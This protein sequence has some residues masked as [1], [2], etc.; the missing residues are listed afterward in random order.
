MTSV[1]E[2]GS[3]FVLYLPEKTETAGAAA[4]P[5]EPGKGEE[6]KEDTARPPVQIPE[7]IPEEVSDDRKTIQP[8]DRTILLIE[9]DPT[10]LKIL[11]DLSREQGF[12]CLVAGNGE[13]GLHLAE[14]YTPNAIILDIGLPGMD[15]WS[16][17]ARLKENSATRHIPVHIISATDRPL[18]AMKMGAVDFLV[19]PVSP[20]DLE[21]A[22][23]KLKYVISKPVKDLLV[24]EDDAASRRAISKIIGN[25]DVKITSVASASGAYEALM[26]KSFDCMIL[27]LNLPDMPG[28]RLLEKIHDSESIG[29]IPIIVY[30]GR[31]L[32]PEEKALIDRYSETT[33]IKGVDS[34]NKLL[35]ETALF[36]HRVES[37]LPEAQQKILEMMHDKESI[38]EAKKIL[39]VDD[40]MRNVYS[41]KKILEDKTME[42]LVG[43][44]GIEG[45]ARLKE[46]PDIALVL[47][48][49][50][51][52]EMDGYEAMR[53]IRSQQQF[54]ELPVIALTAKAMKGDRAKCIEA[55]ASD[56][57]AKP[58]DV[59]RLLSMMRVWL[60]GR[61]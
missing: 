53:R 25:G 38:F 13:N 19:K 49:I 27:D 10:F 20:E 39:V 5:D 46:N 36:L 52:P 23:G 16:V 34:H 47:M 45:L 42:V 31:E 29:H 8:E 56:Y 41:L 7:S 51:M 40:D 15:G 60:Y 43:K 17:M 24:V 22:F 21:K 12:Q 26:S 44:N 6:E 57:L 48:D 11:R 61:S 28:T 35:D 54:K 37:D 14:C 33:I 32:T 50:M 59:D 9:D 55:G 30:T 1:P 3:T 4:T 2:Q 18:E 58:V